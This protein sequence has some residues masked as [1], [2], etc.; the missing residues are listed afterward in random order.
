MTDQQ[1]VSSTLVRTAPVRAIRHDW[2]L[3][4]LAGEEIDTALLEQYGFQSGTYY[5]V[6]IY[7]PHHTA[8]MSSVQLAGILQ[9]EAMRR[10]ICGPVAAYEGDS[11]VLFHPVE[12][13]QQTARL[14]LKTEVIR[15]QLS[16]RLCEVDVH[17]GVGRP[18]QGMDNLRQSFREA[19]EAL[20]ISAE[21]KIQ[22]RPTFF[23]NSSL[24]HLLR[25]LKSPESLQH[26]CD[27]WL[28]ELIVYDNRQHSGLL[29]TLRA[30]FTNNG[31]TALT[32]KELRIHRNT[33]AYRLNR[34]AEITRL[35]LE[36]A[37]VRLNL[38][39]ALKARE[40]LV[41]V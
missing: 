29:D 31:N 21:L 17:C 27:S 33:L 2:L 30:Y 11:A 3:D 24:F 16:V 39:L 32:A 25:S 1:I 9:S 40:V 41:A 14:K 8:N 7:R 18:A 10:N 26:F 6:V 15:K 35:D 4:W 19:E 5:A 12:D 22:T 13:P 37:D 28:G 38:H 20:Q 34:I 23:G 36:D